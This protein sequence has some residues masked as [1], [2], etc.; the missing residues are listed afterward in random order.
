MLT[1]TVFS[2]LGTAILGA[3]HAGNTSKRQFEIESTAEN[4][5]RNQ[6]ESVFEQVYQNPEDS[7]ISPGVS[8]VGITPPDG[9]SLQT[10]ALVYDVTTDDIEKVRVNVYHDGQLVKTPETVRAKR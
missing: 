9:F 10:Q 1:I 3:M 5:I 4:L 2:V 7:S 8:Y 6:M